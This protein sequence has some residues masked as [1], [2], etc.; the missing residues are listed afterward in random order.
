MVIVRYLGNLVKLII[1]GFLGFSNFCKISISVNG[2]FVP[3]RYLNSR[4]SRPVGNMHI[5][6]IAA[7]YVKIIS[8]DFGTIW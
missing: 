3:F 1:S 2:I 8:R 7:R 4:I 5:F 6:V